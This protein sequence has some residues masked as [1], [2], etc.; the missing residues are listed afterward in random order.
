MVRLG[1][2]LSQGLYFWGVTMAGRF[3]GLVAMGI[4]A[5]LL[6]HA[7]PMASGHWHGRQRGADDACRR[8]HM[9]T[10]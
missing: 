3:G 6:A 10:G 7:V 5:A 2:A 8:G 1:N 4:F 9:D